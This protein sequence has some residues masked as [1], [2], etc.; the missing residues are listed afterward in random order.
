MLCLRGAIVAAAT[1]VSTTSAQDAPASAVNAGSAS[2]TAATQILDKLDDA[3]K[4]RAKD[5]SYEGLI[6]FYMG[7]GTG[8]R[9]SIGL[10]RGN[11][12]LTDSCMAA[13]KDVSRHP[14]EICMLII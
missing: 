11:V 5:S 4:Q 6:Q 14:D 12:A 3:S 7:W 10:W 13:R 8:I 1:S 2:Q 9:N